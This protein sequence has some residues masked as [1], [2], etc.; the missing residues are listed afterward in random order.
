MTNIISSDCTLTQPQGY[1]IY[2]FFDEDLIVQPLYS[3]LIAVNDPGV[4]QTL[5]SLQLTM[6]SNG[7]FYT[8][9]TNYSDQLVYFDNLIIRHCCGRE[10]LD[11][12]YQFNKS[13]NCP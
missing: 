7:N 8:Y 1:L 2:V 9:L 3:G 11:N 4:L 5:Q 13:I 12:L 6:P 10:K